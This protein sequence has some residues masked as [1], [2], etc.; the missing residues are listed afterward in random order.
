M[1]TIFISAALT[2]LAALTVAGLVRK[3]NRRL[4][5]IAAKAR[6]QGITSDGDEIEN[7]LFY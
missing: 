1:K 2:L 5:R 4:D 7:H 3:S 6:E